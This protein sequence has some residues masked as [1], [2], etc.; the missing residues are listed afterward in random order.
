MGEERNAN[1]ILVRKFERK[2][3]LGG[4]RLGWEDNFKMDLR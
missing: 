3:P 2:R 4:T 1:R